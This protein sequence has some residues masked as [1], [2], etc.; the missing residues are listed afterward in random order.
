MGLPSRILE[1][2]VFPARM[3]LLLQWLDLVDQPIGSH[4]YS[5][6]NFFLQHV[7]LVGQGSNLG[8]LDRSQ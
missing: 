4:A 2:T 1:T 8:K 5:C 3:D 7:E 6:F